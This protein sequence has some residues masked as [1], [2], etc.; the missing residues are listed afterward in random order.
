MNTLETTPAIDTFYH[1]ENRQAVQVFLKQHPT[2]EEFLR[3]LVDIIY[4][5]Y[6]EIHKSL[7]LWVSPVDGDTHL[8]LKLYSDLEA[9]DEITAKEN[10]LFEIL[11]QNQ[12]IDGLNYVV[13]SQHWKHV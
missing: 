13:I 8:Y 10:Q 11:E 5:V 2:T 4:D 12:L 3:R 1:L 6:G 7:E 9:D